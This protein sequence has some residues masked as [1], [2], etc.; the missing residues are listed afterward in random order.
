MIQRAKSKL[1]PKRGFFSCSKCSSSKKKDP[2]N[3]RTAQ[4][5]DERKKTLIILLEGTFTYNTTSTLKQKS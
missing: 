1:K 2:I 3:S 5:L 4:Q